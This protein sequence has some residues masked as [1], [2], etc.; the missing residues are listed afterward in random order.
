MAARL[1]SKDFLVFCQK[2]SDANGCGVPGEG[3]T[4]TEVQKEGY[5]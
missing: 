1:L 4:I 5:R 3:N 2:R